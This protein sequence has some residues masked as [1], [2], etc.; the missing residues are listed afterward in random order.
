MATA[1]LRRRAGSRFQVTKSV[2]SLL[3]GAAIKD[4]YIESVDEFVTDYI[5]RLKGSCLRGRAH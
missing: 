1:I 4:G 2:T 3:I 5:P